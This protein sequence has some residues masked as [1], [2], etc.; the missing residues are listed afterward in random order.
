MVKEIQ[1]GSFSWHGDGFEVP[2]KLDE[3]RF[4]RGYKDAINGEPVKEASAA[5]LDGYHVGKTN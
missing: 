4:D 5:Y 2:T 1:K 3:Q